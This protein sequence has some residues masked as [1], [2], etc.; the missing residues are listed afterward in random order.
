MNTIKYIAGVFCLSLLTACNSWLDVEPE[1][2]VDEKKLF[3]TE[4][5]FKDAISGVYAEMASSS[6]YGETLSFE[7]LD[8]LAQEYDYEA[9]DNQ[10]NDYYKLADYDYEYSTNKSRVVSIWNNMYSVIAEINNILKWIDKNGAVMSTRTMHQI[11]GQCYLTRA[12]LHYDLLRLFAPNVK[13][14]PNEKAIPYVETF[15]VKPTDRETVAGVIK[16]VKADIETAKSELKDNDPIM[17]AVPYQIADKL[18][19]ADTYIAVANYYAADALLARVLLDEGEYQEAE[20][21]AQR[22]IDSGKFHLLDAEKS[23]NVPSDSL[24]YLFNDEQIFAVR[25]TEI[26]TY[27]ENIH[28]GK[29]TESSSSRAALPL[30]TNINSIYDGINDDVRLAN[31]VQAS[32]GYLVKYA[33]ENKKFYPKQVLLSLSEMYLIVAEAQMRLNESDALETLNTLRRTRILNASL[34]DKGEISQSVLIS[35]MRREFLGEGQL[36]FQYKRLNSP[37]L[38]VLND[39]PASNDVFVLPIPENE[40]EY[41]NY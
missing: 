21:A 15:G 30:A 31:W 16:K 39:V 32:T 4:Q 34:S 13:L 2:S 22:V 3:S 1:T 20:S 14:A 17:Q 26:R 5:G 28:L 23:I 29:V 19:E 8:I 35:E 33:K 40:K 27:S 41:G 37:I 6:L 38:N 9:L 18:Y 10:Y 11:K 12:Y 25:N 24:D 7:V 36:F